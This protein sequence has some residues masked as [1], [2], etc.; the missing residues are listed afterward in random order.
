[1][2]S[3]DPA[4]EILDLT[5][6]YGRAAAVDRLSF[7]VPRGSVTG[8]LG[9]NGAG[10]TTTMRVLLG[11]A[12]PTSG[13]A[14]VLGGRYRALDMP[15]RRVGAALEITG[16]HP[17]RTARNHL[18]VV[19][20]QAGLN[21]Q[22]TEAVLALTGMGEYGDSK[23]RGF[24]FGMR[25]RLALAASL[26]GEPEVLVLDEPANGL[27]PAGVAWLR[28]FLRRF[29]DGG[30]AVLISS[31]ILSEI[32]EVAN[33]VVVIDRGALVTQGS[34]QELT[35]AAGEAVLVR[36]P[37]ADR[38]RA[39]LERAGAMVVVE[40]DGA[41]AVRSLA[42]QEVGRIAADEYAVLHEL[43]QRTSTLEDAFLSL[44]GGY[45][46]PPARPDAPEASR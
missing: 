20:L 10:K 2:S 37:D 33:R 1:M 25:Q 18:R 46:T 29:V 16:F 32:A 35:T 22:R 3:D 30:G 36:S 43:S 13:E 4:I 42:I 27:D 31:H 40:A 28:G 45:A 23:V 11:L 6:R 21:E 12:S 17:G 38:L 14:H 26:L 8:F 44:T 41:L 5:K 15:L 9:P 24:S 39:A 19:C 7:S 34:V